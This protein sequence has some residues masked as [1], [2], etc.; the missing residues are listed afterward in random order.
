MAKGT[1]KITAPNE[2]F[3]GVIAGIAFATGVAHVESNETGRIDWFRRKG[4]GVGDAK[5]SVPDDQPQT[6]AQDTGREDGDGTKVDHSTRD[7][8]GLTNKS[9][10]ELRKIA[11]DRKIA[12][13]SGLNKGDLMKVLARADSKSPDETA[14]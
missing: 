5:P 4:Y 12:G 7:V 6:E 11:K 3:T 9:V 10:K 1:T 8:A 2:N 13:V 14:G